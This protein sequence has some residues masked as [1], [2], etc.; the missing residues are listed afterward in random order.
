MPK[1]AGTEWPSEPRTL[2]K[3]QIYRRYV[4]CWMGKILQRFPSASI[5]DA[6]AGP[7]RYSDG[8]AGSPIVIARAF[9]EHRARR[10]FGTLRLICNE[11]RTDRREL[12]RRR[13]LELPP[14]SGLNAMVLPTTRFE[15]AH[16]T[17]DELAHP[18]G[19]PLPTLWVL[20]PFDINGLPLN[21]VSRCL[22][23]PRDE[24][25]ITW[26][27]D[28]IYRFCEAPGM[29]LAL[30]RHFG[31]DHWRAA[32]ATT[33]EHQR[34]DALMSQYLARLESFAN[35]RTGT[36]SI[37]S[38]NASARYSIILATHSDKGLECWNPVKWDL[39][40]AA[41]KTVSERQGPQAVLF[42]D[43]DRLR[44]ALLRRAGS[45]A[46]FEELRAEATHLGFKESHLR[47]TLDELRHDGLAV[48]EHPLDAAARSR[49][50]SNSLIRFYPRDGGD[51]PSDA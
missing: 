16:R 4:Q 31:G 2:L 43:R 32:L 24:V 27:A 19:D 18:N 26:F 1:P 5:V 21:L 14:H 49:W 22:A 3:H 33:G 9:L 20:D 34:K 41:G 13:V 8:P 7:G 25:L 6:F 40:P 37:S 47:T 48:R 28:E 30:D 38:K 29:Q 11:A 39:D 44:H 50:P 51:R 35:V 10:R 36:L 23:K 17:I 42:E 12:L 46:S 45:G 15:A